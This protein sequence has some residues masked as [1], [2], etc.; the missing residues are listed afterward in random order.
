MEFDELKKEILRRAHDKDACIG[1]YKRAAAANNADEL[2]EVVKDNIA[3]AI[4]D[5][6]LTAEDIERLFGEGLCNAHDIY[7]RNHQTLRDKVSVH[8]GSSTSKHYGSSRSEH[9]GSSTSEHYD[10]SASKHYHSSTSKHYDSSASKHYDSSRSEHFGSST[11]KH[12]DSSRSEHFGSSTS[13]H[14]GSSTSKHYDSSTSEHFG[15]STSICTNVAT[16][17][18]LFERAILRDTQTNTLYMCTDAINI[19]FQEDK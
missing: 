10:S 4:S 6:M 5:G 3:W 11:S 15:S 14:Y 7:F 19:I 18:R 16:A 12:Y 13:E 2:L 8:F 9:F 17:H 1:E